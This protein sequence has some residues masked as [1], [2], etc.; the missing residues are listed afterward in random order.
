MTDPD[1]LARSLSPTQR[2]CIL[3]FSDAEEW[4]RSG[5]GMARLWPDLVYGHKWAQH[6]TLIALARRGIADEVE[7]GVHDAFRLTALGLLVQFYVRQQDRG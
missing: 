2:H 4:D 5:H 7:L 3:R 6:R 1:T